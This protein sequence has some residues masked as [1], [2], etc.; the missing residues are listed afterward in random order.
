[1]YALTLSIALLFLLLLC[2]IV[3]YMSFFKQFK[4]MQ[5]CSCS[6]ES[7]KYIGKQLNGQTFGGEISENFDGYG[8]ATTQKPA[9]GRKEV[10]LNT[11]STLRPINHNFNFSDNM[12]PEIMKSQQDIENVKN[13]IRQLVG[14]RP[15]DE[16]LFTSS[17]S[18]CFAT[19]FNWL[20]KILPF[21]VVL[22]SSFDH[23]VVQENAE[24]YGFG[25]EQRLDR[26]IIPD[27][28]NAIVLTQV[29]ATTGE[30][31]DLEIIL[32]QLSRYSFLNDY[33][34]GEKS[35]KMIAD[36]IDYNYTLQ[37]KPLIIV[38]AT[39]SLTKINIG[40]HAYEMDVDVVVASLHKIGFPINFSGVMII[41]KNVLGSFVPLIGGNQQH[42]M[43]GG[44]VNMAAII[45]NA[46]L[47]DKKDDYTKRIDV[48]EKTYKYFTENGLD[49]YKPQNRHLYNTFLIDSGKKCPL[50]VINELATKYGIYVSPKTACTSETIA[51]ENPE[52]CTDDG[53]RNT[54]G[55]KYIDENET[56]GRN[57]FARSANKR[58]EKHIPYE[59]AIRVSFNEPEIL[60]PDVLKHIIK[61]IRD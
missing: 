44:S 26:M 10:Y 39:Q 14:A 2:V 1:M 36:D 53:R 40:M 12:Y 54:F 20:H 24:L 60:T 43:R 56:A 47:L 33:I 29:S 59:N 22:G 46:E 23:P 16:I 25:Y 15:D 45:D 49:V 7:V 8:Y 42:G 11:N 37:Y 35:P 9:L 6:P 18:E 13:K 50:N 32:K 52:E 17:C 61:E 34:A 57:V 30:I 58:K 27:N 51:E 28:V 19:V 21:G 4:K 48:W 3:V 55:G 31:M 38:D 41:S 5:D